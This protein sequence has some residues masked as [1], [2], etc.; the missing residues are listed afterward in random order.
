[1]I[2]SERAL[3]HQHAM[4]PK[5]LIMI[6]STVVILT[7]AYFFTLFAIHGFSPD[8]LEINRC[9][10]SGGRWDAKNRRCEKIPEAYIPPPLSEP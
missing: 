7:A 4:P 5:A 6:F 9:V 2:V 10:E 1:M 3:A 8:F